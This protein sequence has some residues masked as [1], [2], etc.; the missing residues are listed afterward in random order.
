MNKKSKIFRVKQ[1]IHQGGVLSPESFNQYITLLCY[2]LHGIEIMALG[3]VIDDINI[4]IENLSSEALRFRPREEISAT[5]ATTTLFTTWTE[6]AIRGRHL[7]PTTNY[8]KFLDFDF[9]VFH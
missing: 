9:H 1:D 2:T 4:L 3:A 8:P 5:I 6:C 7:I